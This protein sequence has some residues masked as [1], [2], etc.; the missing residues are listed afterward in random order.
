MIAARQA[1]AHKILRAVTPIAHDLGRPGTAINN[2]CIHKLY[3]AMPRFW[4]I[5]FARG[6]AIIMMVLF[7]F[8]WDINYFGFIST[9]LYSGFPGI[10]QKATAGLF[11]L[12]V[13]VSLAVRHSS[14]KETG[15]LDGLR[16]GAMIF[17]A[18]MILT[19]ATF[20]FYREQFIYFGIL[21]LIGVSRVL[22]VPLLGKRYLNFAMGAFLIALPA[23]VKL[24]YIQITA[25]VWLGLAVPSPTL[26]FFPVLPWF[27]AVLIGLAIGNLLYE[28]GK[29]KIP[30]SRPGRRIFGF[31]EMLGRN[32]LPIYFSHQLVLFPLVYIAKA[33]L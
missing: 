10:F 31:V 4:E 19:L 15:A 3:V 32:S 5:D 16:E 25:L 20:I 18:G 1:G 24:Q 17:G 22:A 9:N 21:H 26:D 29:A 11:L 8:A 33:V 2:L 30:V 12:L 27:G 13:G 28:N 7:H 6:I 14:K 23:F